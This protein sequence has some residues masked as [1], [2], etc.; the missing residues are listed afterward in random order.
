MVL[1]WGDPMH[2]EHW[3]QLSYSVQTGRSAIEMLRGKPAFDWLPEV[4][5]LGAVFNDGMTSMSTMETP[6]VVAAYDFSGFETIVDVGGGH[7]MLLSAILAKTPTARGILFDFDS[8]VDG[9]SS[10][11]AATGV[12]DRCETIG[13]SFFESIPTGGDAYILKHIIH[14]W[15]DDDA[16]RILR[17]VRAVMKPDATLLLVEIVVPDDEREHLSKMLDLE[18]LVSLAGRERTEAQY[19][20]LLSRAGFRYSRR[21]PTVG[22][23]SVIESAAV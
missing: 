21:I 7:G 8:V 18:M 17:N 20:D 9:A 19:A 15:N 16:I 1:F 14:D 4:P 11:L 13:G 10:V 12:S 5:E 3:G 2:W 6:L 22:P 23:A